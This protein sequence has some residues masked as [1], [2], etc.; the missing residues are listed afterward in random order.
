MSHGTPPGEGIEPCATVREHTARTDQD[1]RASACAVSTGTRKI[2][3]TDRRKGASAPQVGRHFMAAG[4]PG[5][6]DHRPSG[7]YPPVADAD[8]PHGAGV[9][10]VAG[11]ANDDLQAVVG[12]PLNHALAPLHHGDR[13]VEIGVQVQIIDLGRVAE[14]VG[15]DVHERG[16][17]SL[18]WMHAGDNE[19][20][21]G[22]RTAHLKTIADALSKGGL[23][24]AE[25]PGE[26]HQ[27]A[28]TE[29]GC[30]AAAEC[31]HLAGAAHLDLFSFASFA[32]CRCHVWFS[33]GYLDWPPAG[34]HAER[35]P[36]RLIVT[37]SIK[38]RS[39]AVT[40]SGRSSMIACPASGSKTSSAPGTAATI[41]SLR[42]H[43]VRRSFAPA[44]TKVGTFPRVGRHTDLSWMKSEAK[45][46]ETT[47]TGVARIICSRKSVIVGLVFGSPNAMNLVPRNA[48]SPPAWRARS[49]TD[50][51]RPLPAPRIARGAARRAIAP[52]GPG[53]PSVMSERPPAEVATSA[54]PTTF[55]PNSS[56]RWSAS[57]II[58]MP[59][60]EWPTSTTRV[61]PGATACMT[62]CRSWP[63]WSMFSLAGSDLPDR[64]WLRW[65]QKTSRYSLPAAPSSRRW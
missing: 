35:F 43:G 59:P 34:C 49:T 50:A 9:V 6:S 57:A 31:A 30:E 26:Q 11:P 8:E 20:G 41:S 14:P 65:S 33:R 62:V 32:E 28:S 13:T 3:T 2:P 18:R 22:D 60:M 16:P 40:S 12:E 64:P 25:R 1:Y 45:N 7:A 27:V 21:R 46:S 24:C 39:C 55:A 58:A 19:R 56:G 54:T 23:A 36:R 5:E 61:C 4:P 17:G 44:I 51:R 15:I 29:M 37:L 52:S 63:S 47:S 10:T 38:L 48:R 53:S 42:C